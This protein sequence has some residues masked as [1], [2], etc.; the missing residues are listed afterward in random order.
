MSL[1]SAIN[2]PQLWQTHLMRRAA[3]VFVLLYQ[4]SKYFCPNNAN[5]KPK[6]LL[7]KRQH[8]AMKDRFDEVNVSE[9]AWT[10]H[11]VTMTFFASII[12][13][14]WYAQVWIHQPCFFGNAASVKFFMGFD[15]PD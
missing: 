6:Q 13:S 11:V 15:L 5:Y 4:E 10:R 2:M 8:A 9:V 7:Q 1:S 12:R 3:S 14:W